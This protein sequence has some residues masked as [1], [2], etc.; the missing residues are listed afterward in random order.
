M[1]IQEA[2]GKV[3]NPMVIVAVTRGTASYVQMVATLHA[4]GIF[5]FKDGTD[6]EENYYIL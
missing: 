3:P 2:V 6:F 5:D 1:L 4:L